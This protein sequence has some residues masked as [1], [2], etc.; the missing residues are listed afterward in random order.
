MK[1][2]LP[3][4]LFALLTCASTSASAYQ[5]RVIIK[6]GATGGD[7]EKEP[8][9]STPPAAASG[10]T[11]VLPPDRPGDAQMNLMA[12]PAMMAPP[13][14][15]AP[16]MP[17][18]PAIPVAP[19]AVTDVPESAHAACARRKN[20]S[21]MTVKLGP[22]ETMAGVCQRESGKMRFRM[23]HHHVG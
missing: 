19:A 15:A 23:R 13:S 3:L 16:S 22:H 12:G 10:S 20:G 1:Q 9:P 2:S 14:L 7:C 5:A 21:K 17:P 11:P 18:N 4:I 6:C 8:V